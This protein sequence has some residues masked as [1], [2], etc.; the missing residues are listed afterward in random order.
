MTGPQNPTP[1]NTNRM[2]KMIKTTMVTDL[3]WVGAKLSR[4]RILQ[5][6]GLFHAADE[7]VRVVAKE[8]SA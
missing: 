6:R 1:Q 8:E 2:P 3:Y 4:K 7:V 5:R